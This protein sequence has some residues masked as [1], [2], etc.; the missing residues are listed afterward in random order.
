MPQK[1]DSKTGRFVANGGAYL[2]SKGYPCVSV[3]LMRGIRI[4]RI[5]AE[6]KIG[7]PLT[8]DEDVHHVDGNKL[9]FAPENLKVMG[10]REHGWLSARQHWW[11]DV[12][13]IKCKELWNEY[14]DHE[15]GGGRCQLP[16]RP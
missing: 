11:M 5:V 10:H 13:E 12:L 15:G 9:N 3:G 6:E 2:D 7:R 4:H 14:F 1:R 8:V 16:M